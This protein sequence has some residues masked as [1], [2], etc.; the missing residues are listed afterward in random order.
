MK[1]GV[2]VWTSVPFEHSPF[3]AFLYPLGKD[4]FMPSL[5]P[6]GIR[7]SL[8][9]QH[10][11]CISQCSHHTALY[12]LPVSGFSTTRRNAYRSMRLNSL[13]LPFRI[14]TDIMAFRWIPITRDRLAAL[15]LLPSLSEG[16]KPP[17]AIII[18]WISDKCNSELFRK[19]RNSQI[20]TLMVR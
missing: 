2:C 3:T 19:K 10:S 14:D 18:S 8:A 5:L 20:K 11:I 16:S 1:D 12:L 17:Y 13:S 15:S 4:Y 7:S 6:F 9:D